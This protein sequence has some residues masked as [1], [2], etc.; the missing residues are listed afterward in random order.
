MSLQTDHDT[1]RWYAPFDHPGSI[2][3]STP[4][5]PIVLC[6]RRARH[7]RYRDWRVGC[8]AHMWFAQHRRARASP[9]PGILSRRPCQPERP[10][11]GEACLDGL[12]PRAC[13]RARE[14]SL[15]NLRADESN[16]AFKPKLP[17]A[18]PPRPTVHCRAGCRLTA[19]CQTSRRSLRQKYPRS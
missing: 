7:S 16:S 1:R 6:G 4:H 3:W 8:G 19:A 15:R 17:S 12:D 11:L 14:K 18:V 13:T 10:R 9:V 2:T 5:G